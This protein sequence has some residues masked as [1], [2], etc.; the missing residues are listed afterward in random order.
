MEM[1]IN[2]ILMMKLPQDKKYHEFSVQN[3]RKSDEK[4]EQEQQRNGAAEY[5]KR[6]KRRE[7]V[8]GFYLTEGIIGIREILWG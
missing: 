6:M 1:Y 8:V 7:R 2:T 5:V 4:D 3:A